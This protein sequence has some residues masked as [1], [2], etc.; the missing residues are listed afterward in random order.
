[1]LFLLVLSVAVAP[2]CAR[3]AVIGREL[4]P[5]SRAV[6]GLAARVCVRPYSTV[7]I[8]TMVSVFALL[9]NLAWAARKLFAQLNLTHAHAQEQMERLLEWGR[10]QHE[11]YDPDEEAAKAYFIEYEPC[12]PPRL[13]HMSCD[14]AR[15][16]FQQE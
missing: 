3:T 15:C 5:D 9:L 6:V 13:S 4:P 16:S 7:R 10:A 12:S 2:A 11:M 1:M 14:P 8:P